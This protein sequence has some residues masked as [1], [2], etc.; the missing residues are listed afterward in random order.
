MLSID[1]DEPGRRLQLMIDETSFFVVVVE[2]ECDG[3]VMDVIFGQLSFNSECTTDRVK[4]YQIQTSPTAC[5]FMIRVLKSH[6]G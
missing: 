5:R 1:D 2:C 4:L 3:Y 6:Q